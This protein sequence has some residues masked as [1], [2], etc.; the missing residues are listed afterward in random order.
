MAHEPQFSNPPSQQDIQNII[1]DAHKMRAEHAADM[2]HR[3]TASIAR[4]FH[5]KGKA[6]KPA[7]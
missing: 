4:V 1:A 2:L 5:R 7:T 6:E 3:L